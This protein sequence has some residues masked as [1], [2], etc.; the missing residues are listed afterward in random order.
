MLF[1]L[2]HMEYDK[3]LLYQQKN[4]KNLHFLIMFVWELYVND[5]QG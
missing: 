5:E 1:F 3:S 2:F 4:L